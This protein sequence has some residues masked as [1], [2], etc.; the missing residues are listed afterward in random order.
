MVLRRNCKTRNGGRHHGFKIETGRSGSMDDAP[1][2][3]SQQFGKVT[4]STLQRV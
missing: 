2:I 1:P 3:V 4:D